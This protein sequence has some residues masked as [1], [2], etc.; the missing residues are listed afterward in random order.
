MAQHIIVEKYNPNWKKMYEA[1]AKL[2]LNIL[3][4]NCIAIYHIGSTAVENLAAKPI[5]DI[6]PVVKSLEEVDQKAELF[7]QIGYEYLGEFGIKN[8]R[9]LRKGGDHRTHQIHI[10]TQ[11]DLEN[12][13]RHL[14]LRDYLRVHLDIAKEYGQ[15]KSELALK[16]PYDI[17]KYC[18]GKD[19][20]VKKIEKEALIWQKNSK[21]M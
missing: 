5:I 1:E 8:R 12:I 18:D 4:D 17:E 3:K 16:Y 7:M 13:N 21:N 6:M 2:I 9:Y 10:F 14:A 19:E 11:N 15:L 20:F